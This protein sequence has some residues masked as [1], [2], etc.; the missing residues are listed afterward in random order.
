MIA[1]GKIIPQAI[2]DIPKYGCIN[3]HASLL[4]KYRGASCLNAPII[5]ADAETG[6]TIMKMD[7][8]MDT[9]PILR[10][11]ILKLDESS[12]LE[13]VHDKL[14]QLGADVLPKTLKDF[15]AGKVT[16]KQQDESLATYVTMTK[17][18]DGNIKWSESAEKIERL[19]RGLNPWPGTFTHNSNDKL[20]KILK[21][22]L[23][24]DDQSQGEIGQVYEKNKNLAV[25]C[26]QNKLIILEL[27]TEGGK[28]MPSSQFLSGHQDII[29]QI[30]K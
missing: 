27:Q 29:G 5:N 4:P 9:G 13:Q 26:G 14:S 23:D 22:K 21:A 6:I 19:I 12:N 10:Q 3:V 30:L 18:E 16:P 17:K 2:L 7:A 15:I 11:E 8:G 1:Y 24:L 20:I 25:H 28:A